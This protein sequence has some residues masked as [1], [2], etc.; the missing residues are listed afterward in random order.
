MGT[1]RVGGRQMKELGPRLKQGSKAGGLGS[2]GAGGWAGV[3]GY[4]H[5]QA[6]RRA[7]GTE[8]TPCACYGKNTTQ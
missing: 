5:V 1:E 3:C 6:D 2:P 8:R 4:M 7:G